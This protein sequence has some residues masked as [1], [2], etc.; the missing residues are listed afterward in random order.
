[1]RNKEAH[2]L[3]ALSIKKVTNSRSQKYLENIPWHRKGCKFYICLLT[4]KKN[5]ATRKQL[6]HSIDEN[7]KEVWCIYSESI[8]EYLQS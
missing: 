1:M 4:N 7:V 3:N 8:E 5:K 6:R 2:I